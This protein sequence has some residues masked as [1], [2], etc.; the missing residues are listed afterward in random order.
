MIANIN[1]NTAPGL[2]QPAEG[3]SDIPAVKRVTKKFVNPLEYEIITHLVL[4]QYQKDGVILFDRLLAISPEDRLPQLIAQNGSKR[5]HHLVLM[6]VRA[7]CL[8]LPLPKAKKLSDT[9]M[10]ALACDLMLSAYE[11]HLS[12]EDLILFFERAKAGHYGKIKSLLYHYQLM[13]LLERYRQERHEAYLRWKD[14]IDAQRKTEGPKD[15]ICEEPKA[16]GDLFSQ[17]IHLN[18][19]LGGRTERKTG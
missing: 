17:A 12:L 10:S 13:D 14:T 8:A 5:I 16:I 3:I 7:F 11:D 1:Y 19:N 15:R 9:K 18:P 2:P 6:I 4:Q